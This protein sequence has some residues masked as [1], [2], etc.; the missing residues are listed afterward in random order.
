[1]GLKRTLISVWLCFTRMDISDCFQEDV[2]A[3]SKV[4]PGK[5]LMCQITSECT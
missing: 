3:V 4:N 2:L 5:V 1:M